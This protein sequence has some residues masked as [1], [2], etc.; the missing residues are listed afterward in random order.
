MNSD[1][2]LG[3][4]PVESEEL[5]DLELA[6]V[7]GGKGSSGTQVAQNSDVYKY[8]SNTPTYID[9]N[10]GSLPSFNSDVTNSYSNYA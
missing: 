9:P 3:T 2:V 6:Y 5:S 8:P 7:V 1:R 4:C 10:S